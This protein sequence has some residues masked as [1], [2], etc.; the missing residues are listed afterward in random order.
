MS[1]SLPKRPVLK[2]ISADSA[3]VK[4]LPPQL[5]KKQFNKI[6][7]YSKI[8]MLPIILEK[9]TCRT[10]PSMLEVTFQCESRRN[11]K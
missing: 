2:R 7:R 9:K 11:S 1:T 5:P 3:I 6:V 4:F 8:D 10:V